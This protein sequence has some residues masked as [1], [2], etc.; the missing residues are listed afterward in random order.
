MPEWRK[1]RSRHRREWS[2]STRRGASV[3]AQTLAFGNSTVVYLCHYLVG[4]FDSIRFDSIQQYHHQRQASSFR[5]VSQSILI[6]RDNRC[7]LPNH[8][9]GIAGAIR[10]GSNARNETTERNA[11]QG[12]GERTSDRKSRNFI[13]ERI[14]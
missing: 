12:S 11:A 14:N 7:S 2:A 1:D 4:H 13:D 9:K 8:K 10:G 6:G 3:R 5:A